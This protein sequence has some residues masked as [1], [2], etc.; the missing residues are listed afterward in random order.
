[1]DLGF[2]DKVVFITGGGHGIGRAFA[3][4][5]AAEG[6]AVAIA[7]LDAQRAAATVGDIKEQGGKAVA[8]P[9]DV[10]DREQVQAAVSQNPG[11][12]RSVGHSD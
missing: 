7:E 8:L 6:A 4:N 9:C 1:M 12:V 3:L 2:S 10:S 5:F 11:R